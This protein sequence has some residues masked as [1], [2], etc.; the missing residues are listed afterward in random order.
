LVAALYALL[1]VRGVF[2]GPTVPGTIGLALFAQMH[3]GTAA[4]DVPPIPALLGLGGS[5]QLGLPITSFALLPF[6]A[7]LLAARFV[8]HRARTASLFVLAAAVAYALVVAALAIIGAA[9]SGSGAVTV[10]FAPDPLSVALRGF[11]WVGLGAMLGAA[12]S[13]GPLLPAWARQ[14]LRGALWAVGISLAVVLV[15]AVG[16]PSRRAATSTSL[17]CR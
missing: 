2:S 17:E 13:R 14:V 1:A 7:S 16:V 4:V 3:G 12:A 11:L 8:A 5:L 15:L 10:R 6:L 9:S